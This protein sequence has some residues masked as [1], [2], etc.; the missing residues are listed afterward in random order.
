MNTAKFPTIFN[1][2]YRTYLF[3]YI[4]AK[5]A[6]SSL[7]TRGN[8]FQQLKIFNV[9][10][11]YFYLSNLQFS[12]L[13]LAIRNTLWVT[14]S[15]I[16]FSLNIINE[17]PDSPMPNNFLS[18]QLR[19]FNVTF[20]IDQKMAEREK[21]LKKFANCDESDKKLQNQI[22]NSLDKLSEELTILTEEK[23][24]IKKQF[25]QI[26]NKT[27][28]KQEINKL[29]EDEKIKKKSL[30]TDTQA[31]ILLNFS[32][33]FLSSAVTYPLRASEIWLF[34]SQQENATIFDSISSYFSCCLK[35]K[36]KNIFDGFFFEFIEIIL[37]AI[38]LTPIRKIFIKMFNIPDDKKLRESLN[39]LLTLKNIP[40][41]EYLASMSPSERKREVV[42]GFR[43]VM[44][45]TFACCLAEWIISCILFPIS[46]CKVRMISQ[47][48]S[49][50]F[51]FRYTNSL[52]LLKSV[53][54]AGYK[55]FYHGFSAHLLS[56]C[57]SFSIFLVFFID[58][59]VFTG[60]S[61]VIKL[62]WVLYR[63]VD[64]F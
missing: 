35:Q 10:N 34:L 45:N 51:P 15:K 27:Q 38:L 23:K 24:S 63:C 32:S 53:Y 54:S 58:T 56:V 42:D 21:L 39:L 40:E 7:I 46:T 9:T 11:K 64:L 13:K 61:A 19:L 17:E 29:F 52:S 4:Y 28:I 16:L 47:G 25:K 60:D 43:A 50:L 2:P 20:E 37:R 49:F 26:S 8:L 33:E 6:D 31:E 48:S 36:N 62:G 3:N 57:F 5:Q 12:L 55:E 14:F 44:K 18:Y 22:Q 1:Y 59:V 41:N 30:L